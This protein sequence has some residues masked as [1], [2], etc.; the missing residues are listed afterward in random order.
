MKAKRSRLTARDRELA[1]TMALVTTSTPMADEGEDKRAPPKGATTRAT[2]AARMRNQSKAAA[3]RSATLRRAARAA[4][5]RVN[6]LRKQ[7]RR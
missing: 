6:A 5:D 3:E 2:D 4:Q 1:E 7:Q